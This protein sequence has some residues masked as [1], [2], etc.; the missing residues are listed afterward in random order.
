MG[1][2]VHCFSLSW[3]LVGKAFFSTYT[4]WN[5][6]I[7]PSKYG[8]GRDKCREK[9]DK[10]S[11]N[12]CCSSKQSLQMLL[13]HISEGS[14]VFRKSA[15]DLPPHPGIL[16]FPLVHCSAISLNLDEMPNNF[17]NIGFNPRR[18]ACGGSWVGQESTYKTF[19]KVAAVRES[20]WNIQVWHWE[21]S[22]PEQ[23]IK[24]CQPDCCKKLHGKNRINVQCIQHEKHDRDW[25]PKK[26]KWR[27]Y[28]SL[29]WG[30]RGASHVQRSGDGPLD[31]HW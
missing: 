19:F 30:L 27:K 9:K 7:P 29:C 6:P 13:L 8:E 10:Q 12:T 3:Y 5:P 31:S 26:R 28:E 2:K 17:F 23:S 14:R 20:N 21:F 22:H 24:K 15:S 25:D 1:C 11:D 18:Q 16:P 4:K